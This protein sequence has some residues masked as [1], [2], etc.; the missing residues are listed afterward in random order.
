MD[1]NDDEQEAAMGL[2]TTDCLTDNFL[3]FGYYLVVLVYR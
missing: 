1:G 3:F 2:T